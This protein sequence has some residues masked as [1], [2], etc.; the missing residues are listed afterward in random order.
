MSDSQVGKS[1]SVD[2][3]G[4]PSMRTLRHTGHG[5][6]SELAQ[7][8]RG[9]RFAI[10]AIGLIILAAIPVFFG[11]ALRQQAGTPL[12]DVQS[13]LFRAGRTPRLRSVNTRQTAVVNKTQSLRVEAWEQTSDGGFHLLIRNV[14]SKDLNG[15]VVV[16]G[17][18]TQITIDFSSGDRVI[19]PGATDERD[20]PESYAPLTV[21]AAMFAD[22]TIEGDSSTVEETRRWRSELKLQLSRGLTILN[23]VIDSS[24]VD[25]ATALDNLESRFS[26]LP[27]TRTQSSVGGLHDGKDS[28]VNEVHLLRE[29]QGR[30]GNVHQREKLTA[31]RN[32]IKRRIAS[33]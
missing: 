5:L 8:I 30:N 14:G 3:K 15:Y 31:L 17:N 16:V 32:R 33:L 9:R 11:R 2:S 24:D 12:A 13:M 26:S 6:M 1:Q 4:S 20:F 10:F 29:R 28:L 23:Q 22:G 21:L 25:S 18:G 27:D 7:L 19:S